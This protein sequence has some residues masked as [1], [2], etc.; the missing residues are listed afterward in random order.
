MVR[1]MYEQITISQFLL[2]EEDKKR[3]D[4][5]NSRLKVLEL[6]AGTRSIGKVFEARG[7]EVF[8]VEWDQ[9]FENIDL[10]ADIL[11]VTAAQIIEIFGKPDVIWA[12]PDCT[13]YSV[14]AISKHRRKEANGNLSPVSEYA[15]FCDTVNAHVV[16]LI[17]ELNPRFWFIENPVGGLRKMDFMQ[18]LPRYTVTYCQYGE[19]RQK[20]TDIW[21]NHPCPDFKPPCKSGSPCHEAAPRGSQTG[22]QALKNAIEKARIPVMLCEHIAEICEKEN[23]Q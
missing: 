8:S 13:S 18:D 20:P 14:A 19:R 17:K 22:T 10:Y 16:E 23:E 9:K 21:T 4:K 6:F 15:K 11:T 2:W 3:T 12:S 7:H 1:R 5:P